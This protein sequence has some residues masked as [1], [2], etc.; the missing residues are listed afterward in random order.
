[1]N[2]EQ[3]LISLVTQ[4][5]EKQ[6]RKKCYNIFALSLYIKSVQDVC[7]P[8]FQKTGN[9]KEAIL[10]GFNDRLADFLIKNS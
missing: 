1:M 8:V 3:K 7:V 2:F 4:W 5:D 10:A 6:S 9:K